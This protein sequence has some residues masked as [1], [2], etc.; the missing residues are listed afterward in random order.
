MKTKET[1]LET[2]WLSSKSSWVSLQMIST[3][4]GMIMDGTRSTEG[5]FLSLG[6]LQVKGGVLVFIG[7][8]Y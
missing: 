3:T 6:S 7:V 1:T 2:I 8:G 4:L 5:R